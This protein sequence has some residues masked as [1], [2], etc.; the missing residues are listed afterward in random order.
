MVKLVATKLVLPGLV[1]LLTVT[2][3]NV[4]VPPKFMLET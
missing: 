4:C 3:Y 1:F 2:V